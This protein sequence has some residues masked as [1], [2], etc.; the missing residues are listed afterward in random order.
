[1]K[2]KYNDEE[3]PL[4]SEDELTNVEIMLIEQQTGEP[5]AA[6][7]R[8][9]MA[10]TTGLVWVT[11]KRQIPELKYKDVSFKMSDLI[12]DE[13]DPEEDEKEAEELGKESETDS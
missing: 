10:V 1:M 8:G 2:I 11:L 13:D 12:V 9:T 5:V 4:L 3:V 6:W 7:R